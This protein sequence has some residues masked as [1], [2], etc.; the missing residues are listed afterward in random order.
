MG[1]GPK[2]LNPFPW[3]GFLELLPLLQL[4]L[5]GDRVRGTVIQGL[6]CAPPCAGGVLSLMPGTVPP[7]YPSTSVRTDWTSLQL[8]SNDSCLPVGFSFLSFEA[9]TPPSPLPW[10]ILTAQSLM[11][12]WGSFPDTGSRS[13]ALES[14][15]VESTL[16]EE[17]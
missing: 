5:F 10:I 7:S 14:G 2:T 15:T 12:P 17:A 6:V 16:G 3:E 8:F 4:N 13:K 9:F 1:P 11:Q